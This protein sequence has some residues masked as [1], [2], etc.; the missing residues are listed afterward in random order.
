MSDK[1]TAPSRYIV[2]SP[3]AE[4]EVSREGGFSLL[5]LHGV[6]LS[7]EFWKAQI[8]ALKHRYRIVAPDLPGHG[9]MPRIDKA[10]PGLD[11]YV[12][13]CRRYIDR[14]TVIIGHS[15][16]A[17]IGAQ[18]AATSGE[19]V[20]AFVSLNAIFRRRP[21]ARSAVL[22]RA[23]A[24]AGALAGASSENQAIDPEPTLKRWFDDLQSPAARDCEEW[25][26]DADPEGYAAAYRVFAEED[27]P[28]EKTLA[29]I[30]A[31]SL[32]ITGSA[33]P[34][35]TPQMS[36]EM[37]ARVR[38]GRYAIIEGAAHIMPLTHRREINAALLSFLGECT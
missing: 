38:N 32:F 16:G 9:K 33:D 18:L 19:R 26:R 12:A 22:G 29:G 23:A 3:T 17:M 2:R 35:S 20:R 6:G 36:R 8:E 1:I 13:S 30:A 11:D 25:L 24:L 15:M 31:P 28:D 27:G 14:P 10:R 4:G 21:D 34:N 5:L 7:A 37:A